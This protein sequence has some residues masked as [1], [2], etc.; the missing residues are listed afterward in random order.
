LLR[1][2]AG[3]REVLGLRGVTWAGVT[4]KLRGPSER[5]G[6]LAL[7]PRVLEDLVGLSL[8]FDLEV[9]SDASA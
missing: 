3:W 9:V 5:I 7:E 1:G 6:G 2:R 4:V 8:A